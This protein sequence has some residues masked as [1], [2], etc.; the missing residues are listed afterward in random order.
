MRGLTGILAAA[1]VLLLVLPASARN[2]GSDGYRHGRGYA[3]HGGCGGGR[4]GG[5]CS[6]YG[7]CGLGVVHMLRY[8]DLTD[9]QWEEIEGI[10]EETE[11]ELETLHDERSFME[12]FTSETLTEES[13]ER[14]ATR[15]RGRAEEMETVRNSALVRIHDVL[16]EEQLRE[17]AAMSEQVCSGGGC[18]GAGGYERPGRA[19]GCGGGGVR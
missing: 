10:L 9:S 6:D 7:G 11:E 15:S 13:L 18:G 12:V 17:L 16:T 4:V 5:E 1:M 3:G 14:F 19:G 8:A 2:C